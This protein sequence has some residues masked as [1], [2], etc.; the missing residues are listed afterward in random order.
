MTI[1]TASV[2]RVGIELVDVGIGVYMYLRNGH[3]PRILIG[4]DERAIKV[5]VP[6]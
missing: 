5:K 1:C 6:L 3:K 2:L 4:L